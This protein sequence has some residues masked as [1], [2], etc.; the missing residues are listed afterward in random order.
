LAQAKAELAQAK[1]DRMPI[2]YIITLTNG[3]IA[4][5]NELTEIRKKKNILL[6]QQV[7]QNHISR[8]ALTN[9]VD[10]THLKNALLTAKEEGGFLCLPG[11]EMFPVSFKETTN[12]IPS[13]L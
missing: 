13:K 2:D 8:V 5:R 3:V 11:S 10:C 12:E 9:V 6:E 4:L 1:A 7:K